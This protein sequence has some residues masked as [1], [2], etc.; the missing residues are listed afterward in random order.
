MSGKPPDFE[1]LATG[2]P[3]PGDPGFIGQLGRRYQDTAYEIQQQAGNL[4]TL[5][6]STS[7]GWKGAAGTVFASKA[8][9]LAMR[10]SSAHERYATAG[11]ALIRCA[12]AMAD[13]Q[14]RAYAA[15]WKAKD[16]QDRMQAS[17][18]QPTSAASDAG[19]ARYRA[20]LH[21]EAQQDLAVAQGQFASAVEDYNN[22]ANAAAQQ[23]TAEIGTDPLKDSWWESH[24]G[25]LD[26]YFELIGLVM[27]L[28]VV[29]ALI[30]ICPFSIALFG[31]LAVADATS[32]IML[33]LACVTFIQ[34]IFD[35]MGM[36][37]D[38]ES[39]VP[40]ALDIF[41]LAAFGAGKGAEAG[42]ESVTKAAEEIGVRVAM[43]RAVREVARGYK[44]PAT[45]IRFAQ[46]SDAADS[47]LR[48][49]RMGSALDAADS[50]SASARASVVAAVSQAE[51]STGV[52]LKTMSVGIGDDFG[53]IAAI[54][55]EVPG[56]LRITAARVVMQ[57]LADV[58]G[59]IQWGAFTG[60]G[61]LALHSLT[62]WL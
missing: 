2:D 53:K 23:I 41:A 39:W 17:A 33:T 58:D 55:N 49:L 12:P 51:S 57:G 5:A 4:R 60:S 54:Q 29:I 52:A 45:L 34:A 16:A 10:I 19:M 35:G 6:G 38:Q 43:R 7:A 59:A 18:P 46:R 44:L 21:E 40:F 3:V 48:A 8:T 24:F 14:Q 56:V 42:A 15:V 26:G 20:T 62:G 47:V 25:T 37:S 30:L 22:A 13:A 9:D 61:S 32:A 36:V 28:L 1:P 31:A 11:Q 50:A 27:L